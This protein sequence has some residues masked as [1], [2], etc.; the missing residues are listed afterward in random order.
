MNICLTAGKGSKIRISGNK[1]KPG[2]GHRHGV[3]M[4]MGGTKQREFRD[5]QKQQSCFSEWRASGATL[6]GI[7]LL[8]SLYFVRSG[9]SL[10]HVASAC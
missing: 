1:I 7:P 10:I 2:V 8:S 5:Q 3:D 4:L 6:C 9:I